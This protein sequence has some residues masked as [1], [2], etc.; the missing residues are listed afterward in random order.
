MICFYCEKE[1]V[2]SDRYRMIPLEKPYVNLFVHRDPCYA[3]ILQMGEEKYLQDNIDKIIIYINRRFKK[4]NN[5]KKQ[6]N[7]MA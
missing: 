7:K 5:S 6:K 1:I 3:D 2:L 4:E